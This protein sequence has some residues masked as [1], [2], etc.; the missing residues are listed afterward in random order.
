MIVTDEKD[1]QTYRCLEIPLA[2]PGDRMK[3]QGKRIKPKNH[4][5]TIVWE[6]REVRRDFA[7]Y[8]P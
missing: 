6:V 5:K 2:L 8:R 1:K 4:D 3:L 7:V